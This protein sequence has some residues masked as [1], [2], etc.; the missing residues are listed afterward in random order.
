MHAAV[1]RYLG[2]RKIDR[3]ALLEIAQSH[4]RLAEPR[5]DEPVHGRAQRAAVAAARLIVTE[6]IRPEAPANS[7]GK[8]A[9][10]ATTSACLITWRRPIIVRDMKTRLGEVIGRMR[11]VPERPGD[12]VIDHDLILVWSEQKRRTCYESAGDQLLRDRGFHGPLA[13]Q[14]SLSPISNDVLA[15]RTRKPGCQRIAKERIGAPGFNG[16]IGCNS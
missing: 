5:R 2:F 4:I 1:D 12:D 15:V 3:R 10:S 11:V 14:R 7:S 9:S 6:V 8:S 16:P 13:N